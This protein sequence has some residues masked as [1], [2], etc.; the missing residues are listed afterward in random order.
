MAS[1]M[2]KIEIVRAERF[3]LVVG[4]AGLFDQF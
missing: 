2:A 1:T 3:F 4:L